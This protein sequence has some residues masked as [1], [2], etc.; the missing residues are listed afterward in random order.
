V[1]SHRFGLTW[2]ML[3]IAAGGAALVGVALIFLRRVLN[4]VLGPIFEYETLRLAR[5]GH[6]FWLRT[7]FALLVMGLLYT[8]RPT[9]ESLPRD[10]RPVRSPAIVFPMQSRG[11]FDSDDEPSRLAQSR[12]RLERFAEEFT[13]SFLLALA[14]AAM[15]VT[16]LYV[17]TAISEEK[18]KRTL[19]FLLVT[20]L[21]SADIVVG[22]AA[23]R[24]LNL[25]GVMLVAVPILALTQLWGGV[26]WRLILY[27]FVLLLFILLSYAAVSLMCSVFFARRRNAVL[28]AY[29][30]VLGLN[31][32]TWA[33]D[34][35]PGPICS[36]IG[37]LRTS[38][39]FFSMLE[40]HKPWAIILMTV[41]HHTFFVMPHFAL[42]IIGLVLA[43]SRLRYFAARHAARDRRAVTRV[44]HRDLIVSHPMTVAPNPPLR[45]DPLI[46]KERYIGRTLGAWFLGS[47]FWTYL[48]LL[49]GV[50]IIPAI[51]IAS[52]GLSG[53][54]DTLNDVLR[55]VCLLLGLL[56]LLSVALRMAACVSRER[57]QQTLVSLFTL[58]IDRSRILNAKWL[59]TWRR[60]RRALV[61]L[62]I[63]CLT[64]GLIVGFSPARW[65][66]LPLAFT[67]HIWFFGNLG[68]L[69]SILCRSTT[70][71][72][73]LLLVAFVGVVAGSWLVSY[74]LM[75]QAPRDHYGIVYG[76]QYWAPD[77]WYVNVDD[78]LSPPQTWWRMT[79]ETADFGRG[80]TPGVRMALVFGSSAVY[81]ASGLY[82]WLM[83]LLAFRR[84]A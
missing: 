9:E 41:G 52:E 43:M 77:A 11:P 67:A 73:S 49:F 2:E 25:F 51:T 21:S 40:N 46:W 84:T 29:A 60:A 81:F 78:W 8:T 62:A 26:D 83:A 31:A 79:E 1:L 15:L 80:H 44:G 57:E 69:L 30:I 42:L 70:R 4:W 59:G 24:L 39:A 10:S 75:I 76:D 3:L 16:P 65:I 47:T 18:E 74:L 19:D 38:E 7:G 5:K 33:I 13:E 56:V 27:G 14:V 50:L 34:G 12:G 37:L 35:P 17:A 28:A 48:Y 72:Y 20:Q 61:G 53:R 6:T 45:G 66:L 22:K 55:V 82:L 32:G 71:A 36:F 64:T 23:A 63:A 58:P 68:L 54:I